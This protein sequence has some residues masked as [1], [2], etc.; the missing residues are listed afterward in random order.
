MAHPSRPSEDRIPREWR[1]CGGDRH[2][3]HSLLP[4]WM[5]PCSRAQSDDDAGARGQATGNL[6]TSHPHSIM[7]WY[8]DITSRLMRAANPKSRRRGQPTD[9]RSLPGS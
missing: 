6:S 1:I 7:P 2:P 5:S 3:F 8:F 4:S 9:E